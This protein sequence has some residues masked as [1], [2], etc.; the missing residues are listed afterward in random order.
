MYFETV[1]AGDVAFGA[2]LG[3]EGW[4]DLE[5]DVMERSTEVGTIDRGVTGGFRVVNVFALSTIQ[6]DC[7]LVWEI[8]LAHREER[9]RVTHDAGA[10]A[11]V[12]LLVLLKLE[13]Y[14]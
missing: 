2:L 5:Y 4:I 6:L 3:D 12:S 14:D 11:K 1:D 13:V 7:L 8:G 9:V 10:F